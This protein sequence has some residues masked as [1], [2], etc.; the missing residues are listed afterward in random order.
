MAKVPK[1]RQKRMRAL[2]QTIVDGEQRE[3]LQN[4]TNTEIRERLLTLPD[5]EVPSCVTIRRGKN[6]FMAANGS[7]EYGFQIGHREISEAGDWDCPNHNLSLDQT[8]AVLSSYADDD[9]AWRS[10]VAW[11]RRPMPTQPE[12]S[13]SRQLIGVIWD[14]FRRS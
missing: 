13:F 2:L 12:P 11:Q 14:A 8:V 9:D 4:P 10:L 1:P 5:A 3:L 6:T 7:V